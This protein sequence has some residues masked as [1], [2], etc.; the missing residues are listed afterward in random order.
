MQGPDRADV[1]V[2]GWRRCRETISSWAGLG[3]PGRAAPRVL[4]AAAEPLRQ[5]MRALARELG[6]SCSPRLAYAIE[7]S[8]DVASLWH[9][10]ITLMQALAATFGERAARERIAALDRLFLQA[11][12]KAPLRRA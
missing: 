5:A 10:R 1:I 7:A 2:T 11:W 8:R 12:P 4:P 6:A 3:K 9:L